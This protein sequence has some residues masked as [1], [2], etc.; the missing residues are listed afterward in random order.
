M[1]NS[2][3]GSRSSQEWL[4]SSLSSRKEAYKIENKNIWLLISYMTLIY[5]VL[6]H[7]LNLIQNYHLFSLEDVKNEIHFAKVFTI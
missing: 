3:Q 5:P 2:F 1:H 7:Y 4:I 6:F